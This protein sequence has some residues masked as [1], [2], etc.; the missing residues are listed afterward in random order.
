[1]SALEKYGVLFVY[2]FN[3][4]DY[5]KYDEVAWLYAAYQKLLDERGKTGAGTWKQR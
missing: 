3:G 1:M 2:N 5:V 4:V